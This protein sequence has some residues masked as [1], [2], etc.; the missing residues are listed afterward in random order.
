MSPSNASTLRVFE[1]SRSIMRS[2]DDLRR[3][4]LVR[5]YERRSAVDNLIR[6]LERYQQEESGQSDEAS[7]AQ[8]WGDVVV[9]LRS[10][11]N[12]TKPT[13]S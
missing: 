13:R 7:P 11:A 10:M 1:Q 6:A 5:L 8:R 9:R 3:R 2:T 12:L 4:A